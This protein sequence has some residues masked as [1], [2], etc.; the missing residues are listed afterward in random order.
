MADK[1]STNRHGEELAKLSKSGSVGTEPVQA[2]TVIPVRDGA[3]G[4]EVL[5]LR[6][7][8]KI[9]FGGMW[10]FPGG[11]VDEA[12][13]AESGSG[14]DELRAA[15][16]AAVREAQEEAGLELHPDA[17]E[18]YSH[19]TPPPITPRRFLTWFFLA[20]APATDIVFDGGEIH[21]H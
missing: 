21:E 13:R 8:S 19:W 5:M 7:N 2:A 10:V 12:D 14:D 9:A 4:L 18:T 3:S 16:R 15:R 20:R 17:L 11:R 6:K 1:R